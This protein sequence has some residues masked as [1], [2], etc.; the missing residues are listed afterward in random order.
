MRRK[1]VATAASCPLKPPQEDKEEKQE[2]TAS[3]ANPRE[4]STDAAMEAVL[5][6]LDSIVLF[7]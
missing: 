3:P 6:E 4:I 7:K 1:Q 5:S 2:A